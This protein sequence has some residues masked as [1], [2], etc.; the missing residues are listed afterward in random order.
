MNKVKREKKFNLSDEISYGYGCGYGGEDV[1][2]VKDIKEFIKMIK[3]NIKK[4]LI[5]QQTE[6]TQ[7][8]R[9]AWNLLH[10]LY[11]KPI[12]EEIDGLAGDE[13]ITK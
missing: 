3:E 10:D 2:K 11:I 8:D 12:N 13:L 7:A 9:T 1:V 4:R 5:S 6:E